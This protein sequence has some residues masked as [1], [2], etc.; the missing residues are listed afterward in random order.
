[1]VFAALLEPG[2]EVIVSDPHYACYPNFIHFVQGR[3]VRICRSLK[4]TVSNTGP[5][6]MPPITPQTQAIMINSPS[7]PTGTLLSAERM[8]QI[9]QTGPVI[10][11]DEIYHGLVYE[12]HEHSIL[13]FTTGPS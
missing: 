12:A 9:A 4:T 5:E 1:M 2:D 8:R 11:S 7:N 13:E 3:A 10:V 6:A